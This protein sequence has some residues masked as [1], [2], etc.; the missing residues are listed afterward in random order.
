MKPEGVRI[1]WPEVHLT[2]HDRGHRPGE[3]LEIAI[4]PLACAETLA[5]FG[6]Y[7]TVHIDESVPM[8][9]EPLEIGAVVFD[10]GEQRDQKGH[11]SVMTH[12]DLEIRCSH[13]EP[14]QI[15]QRLY[16]DL[17]DFARPVAPTM[18]CEVNLRPPNPDSLRFHRQ[19]GFVEV[20]RQE[21]EGGAKEVVL[22]EKE[23][24]DREI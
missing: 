9:L 21:T 6:D 7:D 24:R 16:R 1:G 2:S 23:L 15:G 11:W 18:T 22:M 4:K 14:I 19:F 12:G 20:G 5:G 10:I 3:I 8:P 13:P 17:E